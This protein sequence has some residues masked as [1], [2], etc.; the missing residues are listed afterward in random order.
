[1]VS[2][3]LLRKVFAYGDEPISDAMLRRNFLNQKCY[4]ACFAPM[5]D[6]ITYKQ[7]RYRKQ[8]YQ[9][10]VVILCQF[11]KITPDEWV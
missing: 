3:E 9:E 6:A 8:F 5:E 7:F 10:E 4:D 2:K 1:V 11:F